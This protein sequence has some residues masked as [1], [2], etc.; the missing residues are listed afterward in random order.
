M[1]HVGELSWT[2]KWKSVRLKSVPGHAD[3]DSPLAIAR[4]A[5]K[6]FIVALR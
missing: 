6:L 5:L 4:P 1:E 3:V 2:Q